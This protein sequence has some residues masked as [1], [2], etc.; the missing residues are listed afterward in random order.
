MKVF[1][2]SGTVGNPNPIVAATYA[3]S[4]S[5]PD[6]V[7]GANMTVLYLPEQAIRYRIDQGRQIA[8]LVDTWQEMQIPQS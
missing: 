2:F 7:H 3:D 8:E 6:D 1:V 5:V 4:A